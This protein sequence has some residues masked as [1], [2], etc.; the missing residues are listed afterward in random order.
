MKISII[1]AVA[2]NNV[3]GKDNDLIW[4]IPRDMKFFKEKTKG[5]YVIMGRRN[6]DSIPEKYRPLPGRPNVIVTRQEGF[7]APN[8]HVVNS[9]EEGIKLAT[10]KGE[11]EIFIIGGGQIYKDTI[12]RKLANTMYLT[13]IHH[14]FE[15]DTFFPEFNNEEWTETA[16]EKVTADEQ[17]PYSFDFTTYTLN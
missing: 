11:T 9:I 8:C 7:K 5:H 4:D 2:E 15:G 14:D 13:W 10:E 1:A 12:E 6:Y 17:N 3:I 16:R